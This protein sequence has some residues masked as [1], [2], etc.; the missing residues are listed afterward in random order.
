[1]FNAEGVGPLSAVDI[2][3]SLGISAGHLYYHFK[4]KPQIL[5]ELMAAHAAEVEMVLEAAREACARQPDIET[6][7][8]HVH[9]LVEEA[10]DARF[11]WREPAL[12]MGNE[13]VAASARRLMAGMVAGLA[14]CLKALGKAGAIKASAEARDGL[15]AQ[16]ATGVAFHAVALSLRGDTGPPRELVARAAA[17]VMLPTA[18][19]AS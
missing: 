13:A 10:W 2:A 1:L 18:S 19:F 11:F 3:S 6:L 12:A 7:W 4:G 14:D 9:I 17:Q 5:A 8:T 16:M 15:A